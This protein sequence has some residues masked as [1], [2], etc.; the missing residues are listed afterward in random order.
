MLAAPTSKRTAK[1]RG[2]TPSQ[3]SLR[4]S[5]TSTSRNLALVPVSPSL[6]VPCLSMSSQFDLCVSHRRFSRRLL[7]GSPSQW[8]QI[9]PGGLGPTKASRTKW[10]M[11]RGVFVPPRWRLTQRCPCLR[12]I[13]FRGSQVSDILPRQPRVHRD[14]TSPVRL[15]R[16]PGKPSISL[17]ETSMPYVGCHSQ[18]PF[19]V[20]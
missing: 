4:I 5:T 8:Q 15:T 10:W 2:D 19:P 12:R 9:K 17:K 13:G 20:S 1:S 7:A 14:W 3:P 16:Y 11:Y 6:R 18:F